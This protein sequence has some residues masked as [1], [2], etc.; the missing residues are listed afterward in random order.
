MTPIRLSSRRVPLRVQSYQQLPANRQSLFWGRYQRFQRLWREV[1]Y[2]QSSCKALLSFDT[3]NSLPNT[4]FA[5]CTSRL[6]HR[7]AR[8]M[9]RDVDGATPDSPSPHTSNLSIRR[10]TTEPGA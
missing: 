6:S 10:Q 4:L 7:I 9:F 5:S 8:G 1:N 3:L 2:F